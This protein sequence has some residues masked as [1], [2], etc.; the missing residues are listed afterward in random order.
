MEWVLVQSSWTF[1]KKLIQIVRFES[2]MQPTFVKF[3]HSVFWICVY[4][5]PFLSMVADVEENIGNDIGRVL[6]VDVPNNGIGWGQFL[7][8]RVEIDITKPLLWG[9]ILE[10]DQ[11]K[12]FWV[13]FQYE[14][15]PI[16]CYWC[17]RI[18]HSGNDCV[19]GWRTGGYPLI[20]TDR[21]GSWLR[22]TPVRGGFSRQPRESVQSDDDLEG[23]RSNGG[24]G[25]HTRHQSKEAMEGFQTTN[26]EAAEVISGRESW[27]GCYKVM[28]WMG[29]RKR[30]IRN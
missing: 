12:P 2:D 23:S 15:L 9:K 14:H 30:G 24:Q 28:R 8:I 13:D 4:N 20:S 29:W 5:L 27:I 16:F 18:V 6:E 11:G 7:R 10:D 21:F 17:G 3:T 1:D 19:K 22:A 26:V 25:T